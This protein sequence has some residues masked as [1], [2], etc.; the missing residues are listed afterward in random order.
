MREEGRVR[1][2]VVVSEVWNPPAYLKQEQ[3]PVAAELG[4]G[5]AA[6]LQLRAE[7]DR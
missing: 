4:G 6:E 7:P 2:D 5:L 3:P 1:E